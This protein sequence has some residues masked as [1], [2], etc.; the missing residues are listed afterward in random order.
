VLFGFPFTAVVFPHMM[1]STDL[2]Q[3]TSANAQFASKFYNIISQE[4]KRNNIIFSPICAHTVLSM[5]YQGAA[6]ET[7]NQ[8][9]ST[10]NVPN[11]KVAA[12]GYNGVLSTLNSLEKVT[13]HIANKVYVMKDFPLKS[14]F[15]TVLME[16][17]LSEAES[18]NFAESIQAANNINQW[19][20][21]KTNNKIK[22][23]ITPNDLSSS[24]SSIV[25]VNAIYFKGNWALPFEKEN[26]R[27]EPFYI[28][29]DD[30]V[31]CQMMHITKHYFKYREDEQLDAKILE[32]MYDNRNVSMVIILPNARDGIENL[33]SKLA[34]VDL[35]TITQ[36]MRYVQVEVSL[37]KFKIGTK[38]NLKRVL[39]KM[40]LGNIFN[41]YKANFSEIAEIPDFSEISESP[42][43]LEKKE[44]KLAVSEVIQKAFIEVN[45]EGAEA[46]ATTV[47][48]MLNHVPTCA[49]IPHIKIWKF[50]ADHPFIIM[51]QIHNN[52]TYTNKTLF[53][54]RIVNPF[55]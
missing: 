7:A 17:F 26:T 41:V 35:S 12:T 36:D 4:A 53:C 18:I 45:E 32:M 21:G 49:G 54:G 42:D 1:A 52:E 8:F 5:V 9:A 46:A 37:P 44:K 25:L 50:V 22:D 3:V 19:V 48:Q 13:L 6:E 51:L 15:K 34:Y 30:K 11:A 20:Q 23:L 55:Y 27:T 40:G 38:M 39:E 33:E 43:F 2:L 28:S 31:E 10:L 47:V 24:M 29:N 16:S 14:N